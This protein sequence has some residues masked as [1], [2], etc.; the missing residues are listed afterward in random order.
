MVRILSP[1]SVAPSLADLGLTGRQ[2]DVLKALA[3]QTQGLILFVGPPGSGKSTTICSVLAAA[4]R[5]GRSVVTVEDPIEHLIPLARQQEVGLNADRRTLLQRAV[6]DQPD[7][8]FL[9]EI[10]GLTSAQAC[11]EQA[12]SGHLALTSL[13]SSNTATAVF[14]L[15]R[16]GVNRS[17]V[18]D[19]LSGVVAQRL[20]KRL[21]PRCKE[22]RSITDEEKAMLAPFTADLPATVAHPGGCSHCHGTGYLGRLGVFEVIPVGPRMADLIREGRPISELRDHA[23]ARGDLLVG[24][25]AIRKVR[26]HVLTIQDVYRK[27]LLEEGAMVEDPAA[28]ATARDA[29]GAGPGVDEAEARVLGPADPPAVAGM[30]PGSGPSTHDRLMD[31]TTVLVVEDEEG[32]RLLLHTI[33]AK[34]GYKVLVAE[35]GGQALLMLGTGLV[36]LILSDIHMPNLDGLKLMEV[37]NQHEIDTPVVLLTGEPSPEYEARGRELGVADYLRKPVQRDVI[38]D[39]IQRVLDGEES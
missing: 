13:N 15:D 6:R 37:L 3:E 20:I 38:L 25:H 16:L 2:T 11:V 34:A 35:D 29:D 24:D 33:L 17:A 30:D 32:T 4:A 8:L 21:C 31:E 18:A 22:L 1:G 28:M 12:T 23:Q 36:D 26:E 19:V 7:V 14:R 27:V 9:G 5:D 39:C 10:R